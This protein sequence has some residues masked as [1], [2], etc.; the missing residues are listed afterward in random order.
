[1]TGDYRCAHRPREAAAR[2]AQLVRFP[3]RYAAAVWALSEPW[4]GLTSSCATSA[5]SSAV[6]VRRWQ[7]RDGSPAPWASRSGKWRHE[8]RGISAPLQGREEEQQR[9]DLLLPRPR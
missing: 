5:G 2:T 3:V 1:M 6:R 9:L 8:P 4:A 7:K